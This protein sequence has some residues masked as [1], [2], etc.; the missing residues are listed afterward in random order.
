[1][2]VNAKHWS[3]LCIVDALQMRKETALRCKAAYNLAHMFWLLQA[4]FAVTDT[5]AWY[6]YAAHSNMGIRD[7]MIVRTGYG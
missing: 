7:E 4:H 5:I 3:M 1:M 2:L 6:N